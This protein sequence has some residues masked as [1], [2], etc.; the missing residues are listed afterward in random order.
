MTRPFHS[1]KAPFSPGHCKFPC[2]SQASFPDRIK[3]GQR[4]KSKQ[5]KVNENITDKSIG[6]GTIVGTGGSG[7]SFGLLAGRMGGGGAG[8]GGGIFFPGFL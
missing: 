1:T 8:L 5:E 2:H 3:P 7:R 4:V 6:V